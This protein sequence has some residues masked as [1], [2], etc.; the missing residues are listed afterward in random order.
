MDNT[1]RKRKTLIGA[2]A[3]L[4]LVGGTAVVGL[5]AANA[6][7]T[8][9]PPV[10]S[11]AT[12]S[13]ADGETSDGGQQQSQLKGSITVPETSGEQ[14]DAQESANLTA[15][16]TIDAKA[17]ETAAAGSLPGSTATASHLGDENGSLVYDVTVKDSAGAV[18]E[19]KIDAGNATVLATETADPQENGQTGTENT[20][21]TESVETP[22][23]S[24]PG[25]K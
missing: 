4:A 14:S 22:D 9:S 16:A 7:T 19:V 5:S 2:L 20:T 8:P 24:T 12:G 13:T 11:P 15:L 18:H 10:T 23:T 6:S 3:G 1:S 25:T 21:E 17:A